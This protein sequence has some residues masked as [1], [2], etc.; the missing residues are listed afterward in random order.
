[1]CKILFLIALFAFV[2]ALP[3]VAADISGTWTLTMQSPMGEDKFD[4]VIKAAGETLTVASQHPMLQELKGSGT[5]KEN[6]IN[7]KLE[8]TGQMPI[9]F[10]FKGAVSGNKMSGTREIKF[11]GAGGEGG[12]PGGMGDS[13]NKWTAEKK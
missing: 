11:G 3:L 2:F 9:A 10:E 1:M 5:L 12:G 13:D 6:S 7:F 8:A 4:V